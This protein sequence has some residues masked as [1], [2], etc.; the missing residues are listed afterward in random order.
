MQ[1]F[2]IGKFV[3]IAAQGELFTQIGADVR[4]ALSDSF[5]IFNEN[6]N[7]A[8]RYV[9]D[10][11]DIELNQYAGGLNSNLVYAQF[12]LKKG[13]LEHFSRSVIDGVKK[14]LPN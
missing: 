9:A 3:F 6:A 4:K 8:I 11:R 7:A 14:L 10:D 12:P 2:R 5:V 1:A 13:A